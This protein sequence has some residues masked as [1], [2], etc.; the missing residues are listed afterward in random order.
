MIDTHC[1]ILFKVI[2]T[3][4][5]MVGVGSYSELQNEYPDYSSI[6]TMD[7]L[8]ELHGNI[9]P[10]NLSN[11]YK[12]FF[13]KAK[14]WKDSA[15]PLS[16]A[17]VNILTGNPQIIVSITPIS[18][19]DRDK[20]VSAVGQNAFTLILIELRVSIYRSDCFTLLMFN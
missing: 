19:V 11:G 5:K 17:D 8:L 16:V 3:F 10:K 9:N 2:D 4:C 15:N 12:E 14:K 18:N 7:S 13:E 1:G 6:K 20:L